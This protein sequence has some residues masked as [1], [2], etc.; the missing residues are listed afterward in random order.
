LDCFQTK[1]KIIRQKQIKKHER[2]NQGFSSIYS[3]IS[4]FELTQDLLWAG[5]GMTE[6]M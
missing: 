5:V 1:Q 4:I 6:V 3:T 2:K